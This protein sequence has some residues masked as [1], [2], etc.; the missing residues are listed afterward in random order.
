VEEIGAVA[1]ALRARWEAN[2]KQL[3]PPQVTDPLVQRWLALEPQAALRMCAAMYGLI[4]SETR[5]FVSDAIQAMAREHPESIATLTTNS[6]F[7]REFWPACEEAVEKLPPQAAL[8]KVVAMGVPQT[9]WDKYARRWV[10]KDAP[11]ALTW[12][13]S[14]PAGATRHRMLQAMAHSWAVRNREAALTFFQAIPAE[15]LTA[16][17]RTRLE[18]LIRHGKE[19]EEIVP[20]PTVLKGTLDLKPAKTGSD[21]EEFTPSLPPQ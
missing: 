20:Q 14:L 11:A 9:Q 1:E 6:S 2:P 19:E 5:P 16:G 17:V 10:V 18:Q 7:L 3:F 15:A 4:T 13:L 12:A 21:H 8:P